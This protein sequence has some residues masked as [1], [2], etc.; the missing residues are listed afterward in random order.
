MLANGFSQW[1]HNRI[2][3]VHLCIKIDCILLTIYCLCAALVLSEMV[4]QSAFHLFWCV[5]LLF[6]AIIFF[7]M[8]IFP[9]QSY[10]RL[11]IEPKWN[12]VCKIIV[13]FFLFPSHYQTFL[14]LVFAMS[15]CLTIELSID[16]DNNAFSWLS[17]LWKS[18]L[19]AW[20]K[21]KEKMKRKKKRTTKRGFSVGKKN[22]CK[23]KLFP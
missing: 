10:V 7:F 17:K 19:F 15:I 2:K 8:L 9:I 13:F 16:F 12:I 22:G 11:G 14:S 3:W 21:E 6:S 4:F 18:R 23:R 20:R 1:V 5:L